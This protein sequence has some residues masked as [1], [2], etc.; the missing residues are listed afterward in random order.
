MSFFGIGR[1]DSSRGAGRPSQRDARNATVT[2]F[3]NFV[4]TRKGVEAYLEPESGREPLSLLLVA[5]DG[6]WTRRKV[7]SPK[8]AA[9]LARDLGVPFYEVV[10]TGYPPAMREWNARQAKRR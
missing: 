6:E 3:Q 8:D 2:H 10:R 7:P 9:A 1:S 4:D 5:R